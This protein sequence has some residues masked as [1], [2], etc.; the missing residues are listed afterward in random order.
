MK[1]GPEMPCMFQLLYLTCMLNKILAQ[2]Y[3][4]VYSVGLHAMFF[5]ELKRGLLGG[6]LE[7]MMIKLMTLGLIMFIMNSWTI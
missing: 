1:Q 7:Y 5:S 2:I 4:Y 6:M 3:V